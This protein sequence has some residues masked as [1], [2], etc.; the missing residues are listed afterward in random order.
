[1]SL[2]GNKYIPDNELL[3]FIYSHRNDD[4]RQLALQRDKYP[5]VDFQIALNAITARQKLSRKFPEWASHPHIFIPDPVMPEQ[6][7]GP[8]TA[9]YKQRF[10]TD[11]SWKVLDLSGGMGMDSYYLSR[12]AQSLIYM[13][14]SEKRV[15]VARHN[16]R[17]LGAE[18]ITC[19]KG[20]AEE[21]GIKSAIEVR[22]D[23]IFIDPD[24]RPDEQ[25]RVF[26]LENALPDITRLIPRLKEVLPHTR[27][28][29]KLSPVLDL[30][31][32]RNRLPYP[33]DIHVIGVRR[34]VK[35]LLLHFYPDAADR[36]TA[37]EF[38][39]DRTMLLTASRIPFG[40]RQSPEIG[41]YLYDL[42]PT[43][44]K[45]GLEYFPQQ[46]PVHKPAAHTHLYFSESLIDEFPGRRF[47]VLE[48]SHGD[49]RWLRKITKEP[50][51]LVAKNIPVRTDHLRSLL[52]IKEGG[53]HFL[54]AYGA[55]DGSTHYLLAA[56]I[57]S[58]SE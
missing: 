53:Q 11:S 13:D 49:R 50:M 8:E 14:I 39:T 32:L 44:G 19:R 37:V 5:Q 46:F 24:R 15:A 40:I 35:E 45:L 6:A 23:L 57:D 22:P 31:Y 16:F 7:S 54:F 36:V 52:K 12:K 1:M 43:V 27:I 29:V 21:E 48:H 42:Y 34:E 30:N 58:H 28:L 10:V 41:E 18:N 20:A 9:G 55:A 47:R 4:V 26:L 2:D 25:G 3:E 38:F 51:H 56:P 17:L 33:F